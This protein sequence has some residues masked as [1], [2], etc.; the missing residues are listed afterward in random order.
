MSRRQRDRAPRPDHQARDS[1]K[2]AHIHSPSRLR[3]RPPPGVGRAEGPGYGPRVVPVNRPSPHPRKCLRGCPLSDPCG[4]NWPWQEECRRGRVG[5]CRND[6]LPAP[7][8]PVSKHQPGRQ[9]ALCRAGSDSKAVRCRGW[10]W[11]GNRDPRGSGGRWSQP[12]CPSKRLPAGLRG[13]RRLIRDTCWL[14]RALLRLRAG[15]AGVKK[16]SSRQGILK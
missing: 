4:S 1:F 14:R 16:G 7:A 3:T 12:G 11:A 5:R 6:R 13:R 15:G 9:A 8:R 2:G 10:S